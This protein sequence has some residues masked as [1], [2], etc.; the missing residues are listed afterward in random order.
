MI[1][2][3]KKQVR[4]L[5][6]I[7]VA[8]AL[9]V[10]VAVFAH[11]T[12]GAKADKPSTF[13]QYTISASG[14]FAIGITVDKNGDSWFGLGNGSIGTINHDTGKL[15]AYPLANANAGVGTIKIAK[16]GLV[17]FT[18]SNAPGIGKLDPNTGKE[19]EFLLPPASEK[20]GLAP[21]FL[22]LDKDGNVWFNE[23]DFSDATGGK[24]ARLSSGGT[25]TEWAVPT[26]GAEIEE[27]ALDH[28]CNLWF[29]EQGNASL[30]PSPN[31]VGRLDPSNSVITEYTS[32]TPNSRPAGIV[33][34]KDDTIWFSEHASDKIAHLFPDKA[35][36]VTTAVTSVSTGVTPSSSS[37]SGTPDASTNPITT[38]AQETTT[39]SQVTSSQG[40]VEYSLPHTGSLSNTEDMRFDK[41]G[42]LFFENDATG[43][44]GELAFGDKDSAPTVTEWPIPHGKGFYNIEFDDQGKTLWISDTAGFAKGGSVY[45]FTLK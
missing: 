17:W 28:D 40:I 5:S 16:D 14:D 32:P 3:T 37:Q 44:I 27:I 12:V 19:T 8:L 1:V 11:S 2:K 42:N 6:I 30:K 41:D 23:V 24:L 45:K 7:G 43:Q 33:V 31:K 13:T 4:H 36:G 39:T 35:I 34:A 25:I 10:G 18:E 22:V 9:A 29:A 15:R 21:T 26:V 20:A 38:D